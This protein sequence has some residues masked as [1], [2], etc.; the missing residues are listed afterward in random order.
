[1]MSIFHRWMG[2][3]TLYVDPSDTAKA[4]QALLRAGVGAHVCADGTITVPHHRLRAARQALDRVCS[5]R[6]SPLSGI[7]GALYR[8]RKRYGL[9]AALLTLAVLCILS[10]RVVWDVRVEGEFTVDEEVLLSELA[11]GG[12]CAGALWSDM[13]FSQTEADILAASEH[14]AWVSIDRRGH[15]AYAVI[16]ERAV[17]EDPPP[18]PYPYGNIVATCDAVVDELL[19]HTGVAVVKKGDTVQKGDLLV[20]GVL[21]NDGGVCLAD[22]VIMGLTEDTVRVSVPRTLSL[23]KEQRRL[24]ALRVNFFG[25]SLNVFKRYG[26]PATDCAIIEENTRVRLFGRYGLP[27]TV[28]RRYEGEEY[29]TDRPL[30]ASEMTDLAAQ[31][32]SDAVG[33]RLSGADLVSIHTQGAFTDEGYEMTAHLVFRTSIGTS[34]P[35][36]VTQIP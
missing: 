9:F 27:I 33:A 17:H 11:Q 16:A 4:A 20:S 12:L 13:D 29:L 32:L 14:I 10:E 8:L 23:V 22:G 1:M 5:L 34:V 6:I 30:S 15:V 2:V 26:N 21:P 18:A 25:F 35:L 28:F 19:V 31:R 36:T 7:L 24:A 3:Y